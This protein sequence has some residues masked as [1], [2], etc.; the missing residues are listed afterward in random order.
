MPPLFCETRTI[1]AEV[2]LGVPPETLFAAV[3]DRPGSFFLDSGQPAGGLGAWSLIG[4]DPFLSFRAKGDRIAV[5]RG[6]LVER[7]RGDPLTRM[8]E[9][10]ARYR[11]DPPPEAG[12]PFVG[13]AVGC[14]SY[15]LGA[16]LQGIARTGPD[17][18][19]I[20][21]ADFG[22]HDGVLAFEH[23]SGRWFAAAK[24]A[25]REDPEAVASRLT[26]TARAALR[27][28][29]PPD[30]AAEAA[31]PAPRAALSKAQYLRA[32]ARI[33]EYIA[34]GDVYQVNL[35]Q[36]F[37]TALPCHPYT[38]YRRLRK[39]SPAPFACYINGSGGQVVGSSPERFLRIREGRVET[40]PIKGTRPRGKTPA[41]DAR[42]RQELAASAKDR[43]ELL[44]IVDLERN[45]LGRVCEYGSVRVEELF[46][47]ESHPTVH[48]LVANVSGRLRP[49]CDVFD[50]LRAAFPGGSITGAPK[51]RAMQ[52]IDEIEAGRRHL[53]T[54]AAGYIGFDGACD[55]N[56]AIRTIFCS[57]GRASYHVGGGI[58]WDSDPESEF[59][60]TLDKGRAMR[61][62]LTLDD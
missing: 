57:D 9:L 59:R 46:R 19:A 55:L 35:T 28:G 53:Y 1:V 47:L 4:F 43:A 21:D 18:E 54:G 12:P 27:R 41:E 22:L 48:H 36:R 24:P 45:D 33:K 20:P 34:S 39:R 16:A 56:I 62:A 6:G 23:E 2:E 58:V 60:E 17:D 5:D 49:G 15:E 42:L 26:Q 14:F 32:V 37:E 29:A 44:M 8:R 31:A 61:A 10:L 51:I 7:S 40:R 52:L 11:C 38:L 25:L 3:C 50:C 13:G 30:P